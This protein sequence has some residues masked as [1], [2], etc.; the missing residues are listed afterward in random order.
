M[1]DP[2][3]SV[4][5]PVFNADYFKE[6]MQSILR[7]TLSDW[8]LII[9]DDFSPADVRGLIP[10]DRRI[11]VLSN[12]HGAGIPYSLNRAL[13]AARGQMFCRQDADDVSD[14][15]RLQEL[16]DAVQSGHPFV[17]SRFQRIDSAGEKVTDEW[18][19]QS[20]AASAE[21]IGRHIHE[22]NL[23]VGGAPMWT[24]EVLD[25]VGFL[26]ERLLVA[27]DYNYWIRILQHFPL[28][29]VEKPL[30]S[31]RLHPGSHRQRK[32]T[33]DDGQPIDFLQM[34]RGA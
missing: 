23:I 13:R 2:L 8:E 18:M 30:Y 9:V 20:N 24:R 4:L 28:H 21:D 26:D 31:H 29:I 27:Q 22:E 10:Y 16:V 12:V 19:Q 14:V 34:A 1:D 7:Q 5:M 3:V 17:T 32:Y 25:T 15:Y 33:D 6:A 11:Q